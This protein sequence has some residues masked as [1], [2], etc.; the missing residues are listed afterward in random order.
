MDIYVE[1]GIHTVPCTEL[2][3]LLGPW[4]DDD[5]PC[6]VASETGSITALAS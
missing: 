6:S 3:G 1:G 5:T 2:L 4:S